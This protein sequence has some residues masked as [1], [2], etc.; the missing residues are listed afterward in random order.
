[1]R[2]H[3][4]AI[5]LLLILMVQ[6]FVPIIPVDATSGRTTPDFTVSVMTL[7]AGG[8]IDDGGD[9]IL[10]DG[11]HVL[12]IVVTNQGSAS[13]EVTLNI[14]HKASAI[15]SETSVTS[16]DLGVVDA[17]SST[18]SILVNWTATLGDEQT[19]F[20]R[21][22]SA[23]DINSLNDE[24][25]IDFDVKIHHVGTV[26]ANTIPDPATGFTDLRLDHSVHTFNATV[27]NDG[28]NTITAVFELNFRSIILTSV[29]LFN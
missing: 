12:R 16:I 29:L 1:M 3:R 26:L 6:A 2:E 14:L 19:L 4:G 9:I 18:G 7:S 24:A 15:S 25:S 10:G 21:V 20:A 5:A 27:R 28:V 22:A 17:A 8:S 23:E 13:G 11:L